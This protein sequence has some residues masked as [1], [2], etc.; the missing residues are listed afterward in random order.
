MSKRIKIRVTDLPAWAQDIV[1]R[2][3]NAD[4]DQLDRRT[5]SLPVYIT[6]GDGQVYLGGVGHENG[7]STVYA[8]NEEDEI[9]ALSSG[10]YDSWLN[11]TPEQRAIYQG[12]KVPIRE[13]DALLKIERFMSIHTID[14]LVHSN[15]PHASLA[16]RLESGDGPSE[17]QM[18]VVHLYCGLTSAGRKWQMEYAR[19][20]EELVKQVTDQLV[21][22]GL[23]KRSKNGAIRKTQEAQL[24]H[25]NAGLQPHTDWPKLIKEWR[26]SQ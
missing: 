14:L 26:E 9:M 23:F 3:F 22:L 20:P 4:I 17:I 7:K 8:R 2:Y 16:Q 5:A 1:Q 6:L 12:G 19:I 11:N 15:G 13:G 25:S 21:E 18:A 10:Y 24:L